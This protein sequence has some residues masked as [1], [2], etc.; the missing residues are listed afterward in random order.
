MT[1]EETGAR[2]TIPRRRILS[3]EDM[4]R[5]RANR[6]PEERRIM[7][8][9]TC[10][11]IT[12]PTIPR[13]ENDSTLSEV[14]RQF[15]QFYDSVLKFIKSISK[16]TIVEKGTGHGFGCASMRI[17]FTLEKEFVKG[18]VL[19]LFELETSDYQ[20]SEDWIEHAGDRFVWEFKDCEVPDEP[21]EPMALDFQVGY[22][23]DGEA[24]HVSYEVAL[25]D[26][27]SIIV[28]IVEQ[29]GGQADEDHS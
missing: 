24:T 28:S 26:V 23:P 15:E 20:L 8:T 4:E 5:I 3:A 19:Y 25:K 17:H 16:I 11:S 14:T 27:K 7:V 2:Y 13:D 21:L 29:E 12:G 6:I 18:T 1:Q 10:N 9:V 22:S